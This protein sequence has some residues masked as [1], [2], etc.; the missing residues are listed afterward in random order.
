MREHRR[1]FQVQICGPKYIK[2][3]FLPLSLSLQFIQTEREIVWTLFTFCC[4]PILSASSEKQY[5]LSSCKKKCLP[6]RTLPTEGKTQ[7]RRGLKRVKMTQDVIRPPIYD[8]VL[9]LCQIFSLWK[10]F[11]PNQFHVNGLEEDAGQ[12][13]GYGSGFKLTGKEKCCGQREGKI[14]RLFYIFSVKMLRRLKFGL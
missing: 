11:C 4:I 9:N 5:Q 13:L 12:W 10:E 6:K 14:L 7:G 2:T 8:F 3:K 1:F